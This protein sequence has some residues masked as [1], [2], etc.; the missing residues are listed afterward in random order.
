[1]ECGVKNEEEVSR[2][3]KKFKTEGSK[4]SVLEGVPNGLLPLLRPIVFRD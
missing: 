1:M 3:G 2:M 4:K